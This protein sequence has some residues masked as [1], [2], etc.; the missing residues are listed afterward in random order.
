MKVTRLLCQFGDQPA[1][2]FKGKLDPVE[3]S[4]AIRSGNKKVTLVNNLD[5]YQVRCH[6]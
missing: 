1:V 5:T 6:K 4:T 3:L 2:Q